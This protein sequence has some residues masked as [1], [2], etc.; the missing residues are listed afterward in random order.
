MDAGPEDPHCLSSAFSRRARCAIT[1]GWQSP[2]VRLPPKKKRDVFGH[3]ETSL[4]DTARYDS[5]KSPSVA[6]P[7]PNANTGFVAKPAP[8]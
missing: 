2:Y 4:A 3:L 7:I 6:S 1:A 8:F 5:S